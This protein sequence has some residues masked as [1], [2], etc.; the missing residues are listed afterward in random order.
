MGSNIDTALITDN[1]IAVVDV[2]P[3]SDL[4]TVG[5]I[6]HK[7]S[8]FVL[9]ILYSR[10]SL[11]SLYHLSLKLIPRFISLISLIRLLSYWR[12]WWLACCLVFKRFGGSVCIG[13][14]RHLPI[15]VLHFTPTPLPSGLTASE[16]GFGNSSALV[17]HYGERG[18]PL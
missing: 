11:L 8:L 3:D 9:W 1:G 4:T 16:A 12:R 17:G 2:Q 10:S 7:Y 14:I 5:Q 13:K 18:S 15:L 6:P